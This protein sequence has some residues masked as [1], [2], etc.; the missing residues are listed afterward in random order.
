MNGIARAVAIA[1]GVV[2]LVIAHPLAAQQGLG[3]EITVSDLDNE[4][5]HPAIA[6]N[7]TRDQYLV[8]WQNDWGGVSDI[9]AQRLDG[10]GNL[11]SWFTVDTGTNS[12]IQPTVT[13]DS[14]NDRYLGGLGL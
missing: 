10:E 5:V 2:T 13:Y 1:F 14:I 7:E 9:Y 4:Q 3:P 6:Y 8:V 12:R 11:L